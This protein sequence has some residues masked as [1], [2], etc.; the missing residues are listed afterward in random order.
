M[1]KDLKCGINR[2]VVW[3]LERMNKCFLSRRMAGICVLF[4]YGYCGVDLGQCHHHTLME[5]G[6]MAIERVS[7]DIMNRG[8]A[9]IWL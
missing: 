3:L 7:K 8:K 4:Y 2:N 6:D 9:G 5:N 1:F